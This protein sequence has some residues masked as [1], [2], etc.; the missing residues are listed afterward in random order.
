M[1]VRRG[2]TAQTGFPQLSS[3]ELGWSI[4]TQELFIGNGA[5]TEGAP[6]IGNTQLI[7]EHNINNFFLYAK[8]GYRYLNGEGV[9][10]R[11]R[12]IQSKLDDVVTLNDFVDINSTTD[13]TSYIQSAITYA[14]SVGKP[15]YIPEGEWTVTATVFIPP[16]LELRGAGIEKTIINNISTATTFQTRDGASVPKKFSDGNDFALSNAPANIRI[17]GFTFISGV[18]NANPIMQLDCISDSTI[19]QCE[20][21]GDITVSIGTT[22]L[23]SAINFRDNASYPANL[24]DNVA[25]KNCIFYK[26]N[27]A[28]SSDYDISNIIISENKFKTLNRGLVFGESLTG[29]TSQKYG[30]Q[31][32]RIVNNMFDTIN[33]QAIYAGSTSTTYSTDINSVNNYYRNV[34]SNSLGDTTSTQSTEVIRFNSYGNYSENDTFDRLEKINT[35]ISYLIGPSNVKSIID[36]PAAIKSRSTAV[37]NITGA[38]TNLPVFGY[39]RST[40][41][42]GSTNLADANQLITVEYTINKPD[43]SLIRRGTLEVMVSGTTATVKDTYTS[44]EQVEGDKLSFTASVNTA[45]NLVI[46]YLAN[47]SVYLGNILYTYTVRQ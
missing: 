33:A 14:S 29:L 37:Y 2:Q 18:A 1:Q 39:P 22:T 32:V 24:T 27:E 43:I 26:V 44:S 42:Y 20:F 31:H 36:G 17:N 19:E 9:N 13:H 12:T 28:I 47:Q 11:V 4:D 23:A 21:I 15:L 35:G 45:K 8:E 38:G 7:T 40:F 6:A 25:I 30:P 46:V 41:L 10:S 16:M 5:V 3:G 34:G